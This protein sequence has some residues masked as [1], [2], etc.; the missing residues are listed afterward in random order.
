[1]FVHKILLALP[2]ES[3]LGSIIISHRARDV[4]RTKLFI[5]WVLCL[6]VG[7]LNGTLNQ[8]ALE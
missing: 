8:P 7:L 2:L 4:L 5:F 3:I 1:M 6:V